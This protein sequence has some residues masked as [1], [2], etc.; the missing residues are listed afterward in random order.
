[1]DLYQLPNRVHRYLCVDTEKKRYRFVWL[2]PDTMAFH[3]EDLTRPHAV[4]IPTHSVQL[5]STDDYELI[6]EDLTLEEIH[7]RLSMIQLLEY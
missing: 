1:M 2:R 5:F 6:E 3:L 7:S 4:W